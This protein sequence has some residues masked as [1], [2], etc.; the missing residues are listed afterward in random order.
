MVLRQR[1]TPI[2]PHFAP[3]SHSRDRQTDLMAV[4][5]ARVTLHGCWR[6]TLVWGALSCIAQAATAF[7]WLELPST[8]APTV[9]RH[10]VGLAFVLL[11]S[12]LLVTGLGLAMTWC[13]SS[14]DGWAQRDTHHDCVG[15]CAMLAMVAMLATVVIGLQGGI[16]DTAL[17]PIFLIMEL[18]YFCHVLVLLVLCV[19]AVDHPQPAALP[20]ARPASVAVR[21]PRPQ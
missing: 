2:L 20:Y 11:N 13:I 10:T 14:T 19:C 5:G 16:L 8:V 3:H 9:S 1:H 4:C 6:F 15:V 21:R 18:S 7:A 17:A 12:L